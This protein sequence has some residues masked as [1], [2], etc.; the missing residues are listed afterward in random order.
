M[1]YGRFNQ[2]KGWLRMP[3]KKTEDKGREDGDGRQQEH[4]VFKGLATLSSMGIA[5]VLCTFIGLIIGIYLDKYLGTKPWFTIIM[6]VMGIVA[7]FKNIY[8]MIKKYG[9]TGG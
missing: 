2:K 1:P 7:G 9:A 4:G 5:M 6:L 8:E 3:V